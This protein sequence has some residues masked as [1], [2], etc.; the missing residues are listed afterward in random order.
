ME[1]KRLP[2][3]CTTELCTGCEA[4][5]N[6]CPTDALSMRVDENG[7]L[8]P[9]IDVNSCVNC[10]ACERACFVL[11]GGCVK[12]NSPEPEVYA[13]WNKDADV[14]EDSSSGGAFTAIAEAVIDM[15]G[16]VVGAAYDADMSV[17]H[18]I[19]NRKEDI[20]ILRGSKYVQSRIG[21]VVKQTQKLLSDGSIVL[22]VG[23]PC[24]IAGLRK[25]LGREYENLYCCD[26]ICHG[27]PSPKLFRSYLDEVEARHNVK[28]N[29]FNFRSKKHSWYDALR[30]AND[31]I[32]MRG[33]EDSYFY[34]FNTNIS[35]RESCYNCPAIGLPRYGDIT[36][37]D[38][39]GL[40]MLYEFSEA[41][42]NKGVSL[43]MA[44][45]AKGQMLIE[46]AST[47]MYKQRRSLKEALYRNK[48]MIT[49]SPRNQ[50]RD[51]YYEHCNDNSYSSARETY[52][53]P[54]RKSK[55]V[56]LMREY[57]PFWLMATIRSILQ[58][59]IWTKYMTKI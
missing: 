48:P 53:Q 4:C 54:S 13:C 57:V 42:V 20:I 59:I 45:N 17:S 9:H 43:V 3:L 56:A 50:Q 26:F 34:G 40:G 49:P 22:F 51:R 28:V 25:Y 1:I 31:S 55:L 32:I 47:Y 46:R 18:T 15:G 5:Y 41:D 23:T 58:K 35:L 14:R 52:L 21:D 16:Y 2:K 37:A 19:V 24:Q 8:H 36:L 33:S 27:V 29:R 11:E 44:N 10:Y 38:F 6:A 30:V 7:F 12:D 39:W